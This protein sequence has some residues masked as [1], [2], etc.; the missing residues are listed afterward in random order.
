RCA[1]T[2]STSNVTPSSSSASAASSITGQSESD[3]MTMPTS[4]AILPSLLMPSLCRTPP[5][6][7]G[8]SR[9]ADTPGLPELLVLP[10]QDRHSGARLG[11]HGVEVV[12]VDGDVAE[13]AAGP[14]LLAVQ[15]HPR[16][17]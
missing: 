13:L 2:T 7:R 4:I 3:P 11:A 1:E 14:H 16:P 5:P 6:G 10:A 17:R 8:P 9:D 15:L 12:T